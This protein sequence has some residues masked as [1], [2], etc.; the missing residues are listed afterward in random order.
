M[1]F[2]L[3][4]FLICFNMVPVS[5]QVDARLFRY[6]DVS[7]TQISFVYGGDIWLAPKAG[8]NAIRITSSTGEESFPRFSPDGKTLAFTATYRGNADV[9]TMPVTGGMPLRLT[10]HAMTDRVIDWHPDGNQILMA[11]QREN[12]VGSVNQLYLLNKK[13]GLPEKLPIPYGE[14]GSFSPDGGSIAYVS[15]ITENYPFKRYRGGLASDVVIFDLKKMTAENITKNTA[16]DG[17]PVWHKNK[18]YYISDIDKNKRRNIWVYD[19]T[20]KNKTQLTDFDKADINHMSSGPDD[21]VFEA[22]GKLYLLNLST[23]KYAEIKISVVSDFATLM[24]RPENV[25]NRMITADISPDAK[26]VVVEARGELFSIPAENGPLLNLT[27]SSGAFDQNPAWSPNGKSIA[28]WSD[29]SGEYEIWLQDQQTGTS[30]KLTNFGKGM[31]WQLFWSPD[32]KKLAYINYLQEI[33]VLSVSTGDVITVDKTSLLNYSALR[34]F[35]LSWSSDNNWIAFSKQVEN[36]NSAIYVFGLADKKLHQLTAGYYN[37]ADPVFDPGGKYLFFQT[38]RRLQPLYS[39]LDATWIYPNTTQIAYASLDP[40]AKSLLVA[41]N[42]EVK[43]TADTTAT[44]KPAAPDK[45][46]ASAT[47]ASSV[48]SITV[49]PD[50]FEA[51][52]QVLPVQAGNYGAMASLEGKLLYHRLPN[53]GSTGEQPGLFMY[54]IEKREEKRVMANV[55]GYAVSKDGKSILVMQGSSLGIIKPA[56]DQKM[57]KP[58]RTSS[59]EMTLNPKEEWNQLFNDTWRRYRD[60]FYDPA[61]QQVDWNVVK[62][63]YSA[64]MEDAIT[65]WDVTNIQQEMIAELSAGHTY[66]RTGDMEQGSNRGHGFL[67]IDWELANGAYRIKRIVKPAAWDNEVRS[68][69]D[70]TGVNVKEGEYI[71]AVNGKPVDAAI[72]PYASLEGMAG[73]TVMLKVNSQPNLTGARDVLIETLTTGQERRLRHLEWIEGNRKKV[74][75]LSNGDLGYM[76]MPNTGGDGQTELMRQFYAQVDKKGFIIDERFNA[77]GQL[78]DRFIEMLNRPNLYNIAWRNA[79]ISRIP[80]KGNDGPKAMLINGWAGSGGDAFPWAFKTMN[81]GPIIGERTLGILVGPATGHNL[82]DGGSITVPDA[83]LYGPDGK[84]FWEGEGVPPTIEVW[85]DP[86]QLAKGN[87]P[88]LIRAVEEVKKLVKE[89]PRKLAPKPAFEDRSAGGMKNKE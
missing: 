7:A 86:A 71:L 17:K 54:D 29:Q 37:D 38:D 87:D 42:D 83:R 63:Q 43:I 75:A 4:L 20:S 21:L 34:G 67:G 78:G 64:L 84:W 39:G 82:I 60:F 28:Y 80:G 8:G 45:A 69:F 51:R 65:R 24:P 6:P 85:D 14:L 27:N 58:L 23:N 22:G 53:S 30:K 33:Q 79:G 35:R 36:L 31:G 41:R 32:S 56:P 62:K 16:T 2:V 11:S 57:E 46:A 68:P 66:A 1:K 89:K 61:M 13:G 5:A 9:Y 19:I 3:F 25:S 70:V 12:N 47:P 44:P 10:W 15:R 76:Y 50:N 59:M 88:Q 72:D 81:M 40:S 55:N 73:S 49:K 74:E 26:R 48:K 52:V 18:I 77:G